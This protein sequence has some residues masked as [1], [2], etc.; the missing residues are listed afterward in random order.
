MVVNI[1]MEI[2]ARMHEMYKSMLSAPKPAEEKKELSP[3]DFWNTMNMV[4][5]NKQALIN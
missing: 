1:N 3:N 4:S 2:E 5:Q